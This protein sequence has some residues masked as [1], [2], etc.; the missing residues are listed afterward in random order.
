MSDL[1]P[2]TAVSRRALSVLC[3][4][5]W[6]LSFVP[7]ALAQPASSQQPQQFSAVG[8][9]DV[10]TTIAAFKAAAGAFRQITWDD[11][12]DAQAAPNQLPGN[13]YAPSGMLL[14]TLGYRSLLQVSA[15][16]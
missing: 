15:Q 1:A 3:S 5:L 7:C 16:A 8:Q 13:F 4:L 2:P 14:S 12:P 6:L 11:V 10:T 9:T